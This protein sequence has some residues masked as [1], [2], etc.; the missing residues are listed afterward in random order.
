MDTF[1]QLSCKSLSSLLPLD[2]GQ[3]L[4]DLNNFIVK[5]GLGITADGLSLKYGEYMAI[6]SAVLLTAKNVN[7]D[8]ESDT[9]LCKEAYLM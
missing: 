1:L 2:E 9:S 6:A 8:Q 5:R 4:K 7:F 3:L